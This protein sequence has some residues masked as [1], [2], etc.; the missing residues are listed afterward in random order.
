MSDST[1]RSD[2]TI[3]VETAELGPVRVRRLSLGG[4]ARIAERLRAEGNDN[5]I[6]LGDALVAEVIVAGMEGDPL[7]GDNEPDPFDTARLALLSEQDRRSIA[8]AVLTLEG[9]KAA[10]DD[11]VEDPRSVL[12]RRYSH[13]LDL[14]GRPDQATTARLLVADES[15]PA[16]PSA[17]HPQIALFAGMI[18]PAPPPGQGGSAADNPKPGSRGSAWEREKNDLL[19]DIADL[20]ALVDI[21]RERNDALEEQLAGQNA[22]KSRRGMP[23]LTAEWL[24]R[25]RWPAVAVL[26]AIALAIIAQF[27]WIASLRSEMAEQRSAFETRAA[28]QQKALDEANRQASHANTRADQLAG[29]LA[30]LQARQ[31]AAAKVSKPAAKS[32]RSGSKATTTRPRTRQ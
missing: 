24:E 27:I 4:M 25:Y 2:R 21:E 7:P 19:A 17:S 11:I 23:A 16:E 14:G 1:Q 9:V 26:A 3:T 32:T 20:Q 22:R 18:P 6:A 5:E 15:L 10:G 12:A 8:A 28:Q 31:K 13:V 30:A 29:E